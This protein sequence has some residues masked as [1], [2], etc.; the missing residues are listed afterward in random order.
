MKRLVPLVVAVGLSGAL[1]LSGC[2]SSSDT[3]SPTT[4][5]TTEAAPVPSTAPPKTEAPSTVPIAKAEFIAKADQICRDSNARLSNNPK[6]T[7]PDD[8][9]SWV[10]AVVS[11]NRLQLAKIQAIGVPEP[12]ADEFA[13][14]V[15]LH[16]KLFDDVEAKSDQ[17]SKDFSNLFDAGLNADEQALLKAST[18]FGFKNCGDVV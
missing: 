6:T 16:K 9:K 13:A 3:S 11:S 10:A 18:A 12:G 5:T 4:T 1:A 15:V 17:L 2:G 14:I 8:I 7:A